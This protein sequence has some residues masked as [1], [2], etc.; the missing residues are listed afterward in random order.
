MPRLTDKNSNSSQMWP[1]RMARMANG[2]IIVVALKWDKILLL[3]AKLKF[4]HVLLDLDNR[5]PS[6]MFWDE[7]NK[8]LYIT[9]CMEDADILICDETDSP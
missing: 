3:D 2:N 7:A 6:R 4:I 9:E 5:N 1:T 8:K